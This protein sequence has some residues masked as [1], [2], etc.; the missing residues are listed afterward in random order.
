[1]L[2]GRVLLLGRTISTTAAAAAI[3]RAWIPRHGEDLCEGFAY[4][5]MSLCA[6]VFFGEGFGEVGDVEVATKQ[7]RLFRCCVDVDEGGGR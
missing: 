4:V 2:L 3:T 6:C 1:M 5:Y 7:T